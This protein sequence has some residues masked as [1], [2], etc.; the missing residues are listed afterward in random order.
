M[1]ET[2][3]SKKTT[4]VETAAET[5]SPSDT[6]YL[7]ASIAARQEQYER[8]RTAGRPESELAEVQDII[9]TLQAAG[10]ARDAG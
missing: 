9:E 4:A 7:Q 3:K 10:S 5:V 1:T 6:T 8:M 2:A